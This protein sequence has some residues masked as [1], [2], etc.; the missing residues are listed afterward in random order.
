MPY[1][2]GAGLQPAM[3]PCHCSTQPVK[4]TISSLSHAAI[5]SHQHVNSI[6]YVGNLVEY[7]GV[8]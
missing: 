5:F 6:K 1:R 7:V 4:L 8:S 3:P 2:T